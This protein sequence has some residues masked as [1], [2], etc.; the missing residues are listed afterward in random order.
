MVK[1][2]YKEIPD[3][4]N[5]LV[6]PKHTNKRASIGFDNIMGEFFYISVNKLKPY[7]HQARKLFNDADLMQLA[8]TIREHGVSQPLTILEKSDGEYFEIISG[9]RRYRAAK[10]AGLEK[11]PCIIIKDGKKAEEISLVEN[12]QR[13]D[14]HPLEI[15]NAIQTLINHNPEIKQKDL[16]NKIGLSKQVIS[17]YISY[18]SI[19]FEARN[20]LISKNISN[21]EILRDLTA[22]KD[23]SEFERYIS[24]LQAS[25]TKNETPLLRSK[26]KSILRMYLSGE[27]LKIQK[28][29]LATLSQPK[30]LVVL[31]KL[32]EIIKDI[33]QTL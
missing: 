7:A 26:T 29:A 22:C 20:T 13:T 9:E 11:V 3:S 2:K 10:I 4:F 21:R 15:S 18:Q 19:P 6:A 17:E 23:A 27:D 24:S 31:N 16:I 14:L 25:D 12:I 5:K 1:V 32:K 8:D 28:K 33:E 30:K